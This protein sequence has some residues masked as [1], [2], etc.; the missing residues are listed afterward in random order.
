MDKAP[1]HTFGPRCIPI[2]T[3]FHRPTLLL[4]G[5][6]EW[7]LLTGL[8]SAALIFVTMSP[9]AIIIGLLMWAGVI[10]IL[11]QMAKA[12]PNMTKVYLRHIKFRVYYPPRSHPKRSNI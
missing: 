5:E 12:D 2:N 9:L 3:A 4:G 10:A 11:R 6:R 8:L 7:V 1:H